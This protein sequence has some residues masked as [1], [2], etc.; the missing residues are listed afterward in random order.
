MLP[1]SNHVPRNEGAIIFEKI[2][3]VSRCLRQ[4]G[5]VVIAFYMFFLF[6]I[7]PWL[8]SSLENPLHLCLS[9]FP[10]RDCCERCSTSSVLVKAFT[11][12]SPH[13]QIEL[14]TCQLEV[15]LGK[16]KGSAF[17]LMESQWESPY[18]WPFFP[19]RVAAEEVLWGVWGKRLFWNLICSGTTRINKTHLA[20]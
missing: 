13:L 15:Q 3:R 4:W 11:H 1:C 9:A 8:F 10:R 20:L 19:C 7:R 6:K 5:Q 14:I 17:L 12:S 2:M 16:W 18:P